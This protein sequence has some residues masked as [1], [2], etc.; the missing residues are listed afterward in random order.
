MVKK[1]AVRSTPRVVK[2]ASPPAPKGRHGRRF[3]ASRAPRAFTDDPAGFQ[4]EKDPRG[5]A[6][7]TWFDLPPATGTP[8]YRV[9]L[10]SI[11]SDAAMKKLSKRMVFHAVGDTGGVNT[12]TYQQ[13]VASY[14]ELDFND[15]DTEGANPAFFYHLGDVVYYDGEIRNYYWE[16]YEP[17]LHYPGPI[18][19]IPGNHDGDVDPNDQFNEPSDSLKGFVRN[20]CAQAAVLLPEAQDA[21]RDAM[22]QPNVY[23]TLNT[24][25]VTIVGLYTNVPEGGKL[26]QNQIEWFK[27][28]LAAAPTDRALI[29]ALH[30]PLYSAY[31]HHPGSL[32]MKLM[33]E[34]AAKDSGRTP[35]LILAGHVHDYQRFT[36]NINGKQVPCIVAGAGG[37]NQKLHM[38]DRKMFDPKG[39]PYKM[40]NAP[41]T[42]D[43]FNDFQH[44]YLLIDVRPGQILGS[45]IAVDDPTAAMPRPT[46]PGKPYDT[47]TIPM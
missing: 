18:F 43:S 38:L 27:Q 5:K 29:L 2:L 22:T 24:P 34:E 8:P 39:V 46:A 15:N 6:D 40:P 9:D 17:Y 4:T 23:W 26:G 20:F 41:E 12:T 7:N 13:N 36:G 35:D 42:L 21:P 47:F 3:Y 19:A 33:V 31:G 28:E 25:L 30:H 10:A 16:F 37:Y 32:P 1:T 45:Y 11:L 14:M 44:G